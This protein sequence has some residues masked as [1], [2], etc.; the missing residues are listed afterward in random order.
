MAAVGLNPATGRAKPSRAALNRKLLAAVLA[1]G[2]AFNLMAVA[3]SLLAEVLLAPQVFRQAIVAMVL[4][5][6][7]VAAW[8]AYGGGRPGAADEVATATRAGR[9]SGFVVL[10]FR[11]TG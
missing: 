11:P 7:L 9:T 1:D 4:L 2:M 6:P 3:V 5:L 8:G 10:P